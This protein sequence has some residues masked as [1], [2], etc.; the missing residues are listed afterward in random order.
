MIG[1]KLS[2]PDEADRCHFDC[3]VLLCG[4]SA[5]RRGLR[6]R[7][8]GAETSTP[9]RPGADFARGSCASDRLVEHLLPRWCC[10]RTARPVRLRAFVR[11]SSVQRLC[12]RPQTRA[13]YLAGAYGRAGRRLHHG[14]PHLLLRVC[15]IEPARTDSM[16]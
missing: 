16:G 14:G 3:P 15:P 13:E 9:E 5:L 10:I 8:A 6:D 11:T 7:G 1:V 12:P 4:V 2:R